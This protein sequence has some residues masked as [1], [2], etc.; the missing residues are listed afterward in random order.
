MNLNPESFLSNFWGSF[1]FGTPP[2]YIKV[3]TRSD[4]ETATCFVVIDI[5]QYSRELPRAQSSFRLK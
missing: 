3:F 4:K 5:S 1:H 2:C